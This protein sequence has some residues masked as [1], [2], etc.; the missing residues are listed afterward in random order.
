MVD[1]DTSDVDEEVAEVIEFLNASPTFPHNLQDENLMV[2][3]KSE[4][5][6]EEKAPKIE[7]KTLPSTLRY[8]FLGPNSSYPVVVNAK[9]NKLET[10]KLL[11]VLRMHRKV[12]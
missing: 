7:L 10:K 2:M 1:G 9:L 4:D 3:P 12:I 8:E 5:W 11:R 6:Q